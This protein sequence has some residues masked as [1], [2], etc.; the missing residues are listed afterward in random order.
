VLRSP[1]LGPAVVLAGALLAS[2]CSSSDVVSPEGALE[3]PAIAMSEG[4]SALVCQTITFNSFS[5]GD[6]V[7]SVALSGMTINFA[8]SSFVRPNGSANTRNFLRAWNTNV[9]P[10]KGDGVYT[11]GTDWED[12]DLLWKTPGYCAGC[13]GLGDILVIEDERGFN[14]WGDYRWGGVITLTGFA[15]NSYIDRFTVVDNNEGEPPVVL[16]VDGTQVGASTPQGEGLVEVVNTTSQPVINTSATFTLGTSAADQ[17]TGS[18]GIDNIKVCTRQEELG[19]EGCTPGYWKNH[20][21]SWAATGFTPGQSLESV[22]NVPDGF[23]LD[24]VTLL[25]ALSLSTGPGTQGGAQILLHHAVAAL[26][27]ASHPGVDY[28]RTA[29]SII[30]DVN[31]ALTG[32]RAGMIALK[33]ALDADN[34]LGCPIN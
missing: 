2:A 12:R 1:R 4:S 18:G 26:L 14:P 28:P 20:E 19:D 23:G 32:S 24:D 22:F 16:R 29:A 5:H 15:P 3:D 13:E 21:D 9:D 8:L 34:N 10:T 30:A 6:Q 25:A 31:A 27:N 17:V 33:D 11:P 7:T